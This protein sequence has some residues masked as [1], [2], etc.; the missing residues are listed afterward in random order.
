MLTLRYKT[1]LRIEAGDHVTIWRSVPG[2]VK[3]V[4]ATRRDMDLLGVESPGVLVV[5]S[6]P[7]GQYGCMFIPKTFFTLENLE[8][9]SRGASS[10]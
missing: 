10:M 7:H 8:F 2:V 9:V 1:G 3:T 6:E 4:V 5:E